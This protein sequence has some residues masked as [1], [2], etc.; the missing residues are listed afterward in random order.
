MNNFREYT[1][2]KTYANCFKIVCIFLSES[3]Y[4]IKKSSELL[5]S[6]EKSNDKKLFPATTGEHRPI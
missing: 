2:V 4:K 3:L 1:C 5:N 6:E